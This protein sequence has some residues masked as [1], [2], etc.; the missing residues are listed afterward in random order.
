M[1]AWGTESLASGSSSV[2]EWLVWDRLG[3]TVSPPPLASVLGEAPRGSLAQEGVP[4]FATV[5]RLLAA[6]PGIPTLFAC[7][8]QL[9]LWA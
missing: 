6:L 8:L 1:G 5:C 4:A 2:P 9:L 3:G 7:C